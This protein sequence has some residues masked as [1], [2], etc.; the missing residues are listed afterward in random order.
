MNDIKACMDLHRTFVEALDALIKEDP[1]S[2][3]RTPTGYEINPQTVRDCLHK[4]DEKVFA[5]FGKMS[6]RLEKAVTMTIDF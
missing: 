5:Y 1:M 3:K 4:G 2:V 6:N